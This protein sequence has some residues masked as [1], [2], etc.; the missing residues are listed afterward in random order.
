MCSVH[1]GRN[2]CIAITR[3]FSFTLPAKRH[4]YLYSMFN[5]VRK[6]Q[7]ANRV[8]KLQ[9]SFKENFTSLDRSIPDFQS[10]NI[11][12]KFKD[13]VLTIKQWIIYLVR[14]ASL[15]RNNPVSQSG[16]I[17]KGYW[18]SAVSFILCLIIL[19]KVSHLGQWQQNVAVRSV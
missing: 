2:L 7:Y 5:G 11:S 19:V 16:N 6:R 18:P 9:K 1:R 17:T 12:R 13:V 4:N 3:P 10:S 8:E 14:K 15:R